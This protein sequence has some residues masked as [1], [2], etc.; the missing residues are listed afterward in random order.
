MQDI[1]HVAVIGS[2]CA[3]K[4]WTRTDRQTTDNIWTDIQPDFM[5]RLAMANRIKK[6]NK[7]KAG[8]K[9]ERG[10]KMMLTA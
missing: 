7:L 10:N 9:L 4:V 5:I 1:I 3:T 8:K 2:F 6:P